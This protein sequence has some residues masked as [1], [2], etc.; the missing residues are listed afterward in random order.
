MFRITKASFLVLAVWLFV[1]CSDDKLDTYF[2]F[3]GHEQRKSGNT[4]PI[5]FKKDAELPE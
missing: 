5:T 3:L 1:A 4:V 2:L